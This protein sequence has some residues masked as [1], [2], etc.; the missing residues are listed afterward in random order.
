[1]IRQSYIFLDRTGKKGEENIWKQGIKNW[2]DFLNASTIKSISK[3]SKAYY[4]RQIRAAEKELYNQN[5]RYFSDIL[6]LV[7]HWRLYNFFKDEAVF[8]DI[9]TT[10][11]GKDD[12]IIM[13]GLFDGVDT[14]LMIRGFNLDFRLLKQALT[15]YKLIVTFNGATFDLPFINKR[16]LGTVPDI[17]HIDLRPLCQRVGLTGG[18]KMIEKQLGI[19]RNPLIEKM[20]G[21]DVYR[22][23][24]MYRASG[25]EHYLN[26]LVEYNEDDCINLKKIADF[27]VSRLEQD[28][29]DN[30]QKQGHRKYKY[31]KQKQSLGCIQPEIECQADCGAEEYLCI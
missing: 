19:K 24:R 6:P 10:G 1:M 30:Y 12:D 3:K 22:L 5:S 8:L 18:L 31:Q 23:W 15:R 11:L 29:R 21:G 27:V 4:D 13:V 2:D 7:E 20:Y 25:D 9:E 14:K 17:P 16:Y 28:I 26:L